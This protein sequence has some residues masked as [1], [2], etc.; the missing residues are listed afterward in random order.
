MKKKVESKSKIKVERFIITRTLT[1][2]LNDFYDAKFYL[3]SQPTCVLIY[4][5]RTVRWKLRFSDYE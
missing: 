5:F 3:L 2:D 4:R 1:Y